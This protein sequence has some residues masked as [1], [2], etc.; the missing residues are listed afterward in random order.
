VIFL[1][2]ALTAFTLM[3]L[4]MPSLI[5]YLK[6]LK[7]GQTI[8]TLGPQAHLSKQGTPNM[9]GLLMVATTLLA[10]VCCALYE[11]IA[12]RLLPLILLALG[13][14]AIGFADDYIKDIKKRHEGLKPM[15]KVIGQ[16]ITGIAFSLYCYISIGSRIRLPYITTELDLGLFYIP[17][18]T[19]LIIFMTNS[20]NLQDGVDGIL[21][22]VSIVGGIAFGAIALMIGGD[23]A[24]QLHR[25]LALASV[26]LVGACG[27]FLVFNRYPARIMMGDTGSMFIGGVFVG[28]AILLR[29]QLWLIPICFTMIVSSMSVIMQRIYFKIT[30]GRRIFRMS[31]IHHHFEL[32]G[33]S[34]NQIVRMYVAATLVLSVLAVLAILPLQA[35]GAQ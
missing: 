19:L 28:I 10:A 20:A 15:Q 1:I 22:S 35:N 3:L 7:F 34:E 29:L 31:P 32:S 14:T 33:M 25:A 18:M 2:T 21:S 11:G 9:G 23:K 17:L 27:G 30:H 26:A 24:P 8:Y 6:K 16:I 5:I 4:G 13:S 12:A